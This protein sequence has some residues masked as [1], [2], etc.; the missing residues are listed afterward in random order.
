MTV[1]ICS[2]YLNPIH[3][4][5]IA[6]LEAAKKLG[7]ELWVIVNNDEQ[8]ALKGS[9]PFMNEDDRL[10]IVSSLAVVDRAIKSIDT[11]RSVCETIK[12]VYADTLGYDVIFANG[13]DATADNVPEEEVCQELGIETV[14]GVVP[15]IAQSSKILAAAGVTR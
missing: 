13:G 4:G 1:V 8:V 10:K 2:G 9:V 3:V 14:Y 6:Y 7:D 15:Q 5:H 11:N 12:N